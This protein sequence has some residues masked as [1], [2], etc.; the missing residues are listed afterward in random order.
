MGETGMMNLYR[1]NELAFALAWIA[2]YITGTCIAETLNETLGVFKIFSA[3]V[4]AGLTA[5]ALMWLKSNG[6]FE[7]YGPAWLERWVEVVNECDKGLK[8]GWIAP[9]PSYS[10]DHSHAWGGTPAYQMPMA[11]LGL[12]LPEPGMKKLKLSPRLCG[13]EQYEISFPTVYGPVT[14]KKQAG[15][16]AQVEAPAEIEILLAE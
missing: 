12:E 1:K 16:P 4:H 2:V 9:E 13:L 8:E 10:F 15:A 14:V 6:L 5:F 3:L 11:L 7:K